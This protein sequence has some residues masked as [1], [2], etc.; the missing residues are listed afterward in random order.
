MDFETIDWDS[1]AKRIQKAF[2]IAGECELRELRRSDWGRRLFLVGTK[3]RD[4]FIDDDTLLRITYD[5]TGRFFY[6]ADKT[7]EDWLSFKIGWGKDEVEGVLSGKVDEFSTLLARGFFHLGYL[8]AEAELK[9]ETTIT[10][11]EKL[12]WAL[13]YERRYGF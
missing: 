1:E 4:V 8:S 10:A 9:L 6:L 3:S 7:R 11:H 13:E 2:G 5:A 12:E